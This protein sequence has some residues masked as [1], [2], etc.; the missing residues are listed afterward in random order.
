MQCACTLSLPLSG[1]FLVVIN[2]QCSLLYQTD[3]QVRA[4]ISDMDVKVTQ[5]HVLLDRSVTDLEHALASHEAGVK[6]KIAG[7]EK[8]LAMQEAAMKE[9]VISLEV[10]L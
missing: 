10:C 2:V 7:T 1:A 3:T 6:G 9:R 4:L 5:G 8:R